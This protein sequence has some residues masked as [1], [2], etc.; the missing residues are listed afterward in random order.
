MT[1]FLDIIHCDEDE[2][3]RASFPIM[4]QLRP[5][6]EEQD[7]V[8][9]VRRQMLAGYRIA[10]AE[11]DGE[12]VGVMGYRFSEDLAWGKTLYIDDLVVDEGQRS[13]GV[14]EAFMQFAESQCKRRNCE[15]L[16]LC[17]GLEK[18]AAHRFYERIGMEKASFSFVKKLS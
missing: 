16:R 6:L 7:F 11:I 5:H 4:R 18:E 10:S 13:R 14:G 17:S 15:T 1:T 9:Q 12:I 2:Q 3:I 8:E